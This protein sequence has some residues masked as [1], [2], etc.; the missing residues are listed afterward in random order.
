M[1]VNPLSIA[2]VSIQRSRNNHQL[3]LGHK[4][5]DASLVLCG[6]VGGDGVEVEFQRCGEGCNDQQK[7]VHEAK[8]PIHGEVLGCSKG[9][10]VLSVA[11]AN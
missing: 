6:V 5:P 8:Y 3:F 2:S 11:V 10:R 9:R 4:V 7:Q 1:H